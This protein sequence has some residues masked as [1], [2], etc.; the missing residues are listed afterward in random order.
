MSHAT[1]IELPTIARVDDAVGDEAAE[2][3]RFALYEELAGFVRDVTRKTP[4]LLVIEDAHWCDPTTLRVL[5]HVV[6]QSADLPLMVV[7]T[8]RPEGE[9]AAAADLATSITRCGGVWIQLEGLAAQHVTQLADHLA[10][11][12]LSASEITHIHE[13]SGGNPLYVSE[14]LRATGQSDDQLPASLAGLVHQR[15]QTLGADTVQALK[16]AA[17]MGRE[18]TVQG[19]ARASGEPDDLMR[20]LEPA[21]QGGILREQAAGSWT[22]THAL[23]RDAVL[24]AMRPAE[25][26]GW[27]ARVAASMESA[28]H[29]ARGRSEVA[30]HWRAAGAQYAPQAWRST[31]AAA[32]RAHEV[33]AFVEEAALLAEA[34]ESQRIDPLS[35]DLERFVLLERRAAA[36]RLSSDWDQAATAVIEAIAVAERMHRPDLAAQAATSLPEGSIWHVQRYGTVSADLVH[37]LH[38]CLALADPDDEVLRCRLLLTIAGESFYIATREELDAHVEEALAIAERLEDPELQCLALQQAYSARWRP[39]TVH[40]RI[41]IAAQG[42]ALARSAGSLRFEASCGALHAIALMEAGRIEESQVVMGRALDLANRHGFATVVVILELLR[43]PLKLLAG[44]DDEAGAA[45]DRVVELQERITGSN[46]PAAIAGSQMLAL[47]WQ[48]RPAEF[49]EA[50][51]LAPADVEAPLELIA[52]MAMLRLGL[53]DGARSLYSSMPTVEPD[54]TYMGMLVAAVSAE[55][56]LHFGDRTLSDRMYT[57]LLPYSGG[58]ASA[59]STGVLGPVDAFIALAAAGSGRGDAAATHAEA[60]LVQ[61]RTWGMPRGAEW[62]SGLRERHRF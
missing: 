48:D 7:V 41:E 30:R 47:V 54:D 27:H 14:L 24:D 17:V 58:V 59:G 29:D 8:R 50:A 46:L 19:L 16:V 1:G 38:R 55:V 23:V 26:S 13:R 56:A 5:R 43:V 42:V 39:D 33:F 20:V 22:F 51:R 37:A 40:W 62:L 3:G 35:T 32:T 12:E 11:A 52:V 2:A 61:C 4:L 10:P 44:R 49:V 28:T 34:L 25:R 57:W 21:R 60:A 6:D 53:D 18:F 9:I 31:A 45:L 15:L 36:C